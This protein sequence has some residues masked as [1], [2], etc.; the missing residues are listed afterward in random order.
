MKEPMTW[1]ERIMTVFSGQT[2]DRMPWFPRMHLWHAAHEKM[3]TLPEQYRGWSLEDILRDLGAG[4]NGHSKVHSEEYKG[5]A[6]RK[7]QQGDREIYLYET[8]FGTLRNVWANPPSQ[9]RMALR[10]F[11]VEHMVKGPGDFDALHYL[12]D[13]LV[14][15]EDYAAFEADVRRIGVDGVAIA[16]MGPSPFQ[17]FLRTYMGFEKG[18]VQI[19]ETPQK[20]QGILQRL[21]EI[22]L[23]VVRVVA[24]S[25]AEI[26]NLGDNLTVLLQSPAVFREHYLPFYQEA[27]AILQRSGKKVAVHG[28]GEMKPLLPLL[29]DSGVDA[30]ESFSP[31]PMTGC[32]LDEA[33][34]LA[35]GRYIIW[36]GIPSIL[37]C[38]PTT[39]AEFDAFMDHLFQLVSPGNPFV[40]S[41]GDNVMPEA[42]LDRVQRVCRIVRE[43]W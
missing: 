1:K 9:A 32:T 27:C 6:I 7:E 16:Y 37:L 36:G 40:L 3:G 24:E 30:V 21:R 19:M 15:R 5:V 4:I 33:L 42:H 35:D 26:V 39:D 23:E 10:A 31:D 12:L 11:Q 38:D 41:V 18:F 28:D 2:P 14:I 22:C 8:P 29:K 20:V 43:G 13:R 25:P 34:K 17:R